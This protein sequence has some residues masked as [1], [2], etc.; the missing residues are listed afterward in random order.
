MP[1]AGRAKRWM[2]NLGYCDENDILKTL[3]RGSSP[4]MWE[5]AD[6]DQE[7]ERRKSNGTMG[8]RTGVGF[9]MF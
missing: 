4:R 5:S 7:N 9:N 2:E 1:A 8:V 6:D 3:R